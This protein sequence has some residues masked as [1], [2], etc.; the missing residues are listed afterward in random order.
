M[1]PLDPQDTKILLRL[2]RSLRD[3]SLDDLAAAAG[4]DPRLL[5]RYEDGLDAPSQEVLERIGEG[6]GVPGAYVDAILLPMVRMLRELANGLRTALGGPAE[7]VATRVGR[8]IGE[9]ARLSLIAFISGAQMAN[10]EEKY[11]RALR[12]HTVKG[13]SA[14]RSQPSAEVLRESSQLY[15]RLYRLWAAEIGEVPEAGDDERVEGGGADAPESAEDS[16]PFDDP[17]RPARERL[18]GF[19]STFVD[20]ATNLTELLTEGR[21]VLAATLKLW[22][23]GKLDF[24]FLDEPRLQAISESLAAQRSLM[25]EAIEIVERAAAPGGAAAGKG[26]KLN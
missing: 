24:A 9:A 11:V 6:A 15:R 18:Q 22:E 23:T 20:H 13:S 10:F 1:E 25:G 21:Q 3:W 7:E 2:L 4:V 19:V 16:L 17:S 12:P 14:H 26:P 8:D 5:A